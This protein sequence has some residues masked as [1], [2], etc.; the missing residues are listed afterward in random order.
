MKLCLMSAMMYLGGTQFAMGAVEEQ[1]QRPVNIAALITFVMFMILTLMITTWAA[2]R[3]KSRK[4]YYVA[5]GEITGL[6]NGFAIAGDTMSAASFLGLVGLVF[7]LGFDALYFIVSLVVSWL[8]V[9][10]VIAERLRNL[11]SYTFADALSYR[12]SKKPIRI[13][14]ASCALAIMIPYL[15]AQLVAAGTLV[16]GLFGLD[17]KQ[18]V[19]IVGVLMMI[20]VAFGGM[21]ATTWVQIVKAVLL[22]GG[23]TLLSIGVMSAF[24]FNP[25]NLISAAVDKH[26]LGD[27][28]LS[29]GGLYTDIIS[30]VS[31]SLAF[32]GGTAAMP[33]VLMRFF[34]VSNAVQA[35]RSAAYAVGLIAYF[36]VLVLII[37]FGAVVMLVDNP[38]YSNGGTDVIGGSNMVAIHLAQFVGGDVFMGFISAVAFATILA[39]VSGLTLSAGAT[40]S[41]DLFS[42]VI[43]DNKCTEKEE[44]F[45]SRITVVVLG[46]LGIYLA[47]VF[48][49]QNVAILATLPLAIGASTN[50]PMLFLSMYWKGLTTRG[51]VY[52]G[53]IGLVLAVGLIILGPN[54][55]VKVFGY[56]EAV[57]PY[58]YP[59]IFSMSACFLFCW[60][61]SITDKSERAEE[62]KAAFPAQ[63]LRSQLGEVK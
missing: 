34:T 1:V 12:L 17:Y 19:I 30:A 7:V 13:L 22:I 14:A 25:A 4:D 50:F 29:P 52:G 56:K 42:N 33:H 54:V 62:E 53:S 20:Y 37:G 35:R 2:R 46:I 49:G 18:G 27:K 63:L 59:T 60:F 24:Q 57:F 15:L 6:Q 39:V 32:I 51:T 28:L 21:M 55:W 26:P 10:I 38:E 16:E 11:G 48:E 9:L 41:H 61:F 44:L 40:V 43:R 23:G 31:L 47:I 8:V 3:T 45:I 5:G 58:A 36:Q